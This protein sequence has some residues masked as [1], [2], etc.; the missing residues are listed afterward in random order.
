MKHE[1][2]SLFPAFF[3]TEVSYIRNM[4]PSEVN[5]LLRQAGFPDGSRQF[6]LAQACFESGG[7]TFDSP[8]D[9]ANNNLTG[10]QWAQDPNSH[11]TYSW[12][13]NALQ[14][15][16]M[17]RADNPNGFYAMFDSP[18]DWAKDFYRIVHAQFPGWNT[19][20]RPI[21]ATTVEDYVHR[22]K[23]NHYFQSDEADYLA[24]LKFYLNKL[25]ES[26]A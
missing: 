15:S 1:P 2:G 6:A 7:I 17:P 24:G 14:G 11:E 20:G 25:N 3:W 5:D 19:D 21:E 9:A 23:L 22:L 13:K 8:V 18:L 16:P 26:I 12:Q 4:T 10:I